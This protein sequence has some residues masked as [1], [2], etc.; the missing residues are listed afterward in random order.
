MSKKKGNDLIVVKTKEY[1]IID[2]KIYKHG[3]WIPVSI[4][5]RKS[6]Y[7]PKPIKRK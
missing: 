1:P 7:E 5:S 6:T 2:G 3:K 4:D